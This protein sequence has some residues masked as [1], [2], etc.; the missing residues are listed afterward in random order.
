MNVKLN[1]KIIKISYATH[2]IFYVYHI[3]A[4][5]DPNFL[6]SVSRNYVSIILL[7]QISLLY[8]T[9]HLEK[10]KISVLPSYINL[11]LSIWAV[12]RAGI[13]VSFLMIIGVYVA[14]IRNQSIVINFR[15][16]YKV[17]GVILGLL[18]IMFIIMDPRVVYERLEYYLSRGLQS[19]GRSMIIKEYLLNMVS[20]IKM[21]F[22]GVPI[23]GNEIFIKWDGNLHNS[24][25]RAH[26]T[27]GLIG[28]IILI[29]GILNSIYRYFKSSKVIF[30]FLLL[31]ICVRL[32]TDT[33]AF[34]GVFDP[35]IFYFIY[36]GLETEI[37]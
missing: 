23:D 17:L 12:G 16:L 31:S 11:F 25:L 30:L 13:I 24:Y 20:D 4:G 27:Y 2:V 8:I 6:F 32:L 9:E 7:V 1:Y 36:N 21:F 26:Y 19:S 35:L 37:Q 15:Y 5:T 28:V 14:R 18:I 3:V 22:W 34:Y 10:K 33:A 29:A